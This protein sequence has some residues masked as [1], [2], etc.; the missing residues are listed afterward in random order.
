MSDTGK[1]SVHDHASRLARA[2]RRWLLDAR[3][4]LRS[5][6]TAR[7]APAPTTPDPTEEAR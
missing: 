1:H 4:R 6:A 2:E 5:T 3:A 7:P